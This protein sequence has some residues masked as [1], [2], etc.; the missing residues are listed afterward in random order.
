MSR[1]H[2]ISVDPAVVRRFVQGDRKAQEI[3]YRAY[4]SAVYTLA[5]R[6]LRDEALAEEATQDTF[7]DAIGSARKLARTQ[8]LAGWIRTIAVNHCLMRLR[9]PWYKRR[10]ALAEDDRATADGVAGDGADRA[11]VINQALGRLPGEARMVVWMHCVEGYTHD[12]IGRAFGHTASFSKSLLARAY[13]TLAAHRD[14]TADPVAPRLCPAK[15]HDTK[16]PG[17]APRARTSDERSTA[18]AVACTP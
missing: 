1:F 17:L 7:V 3:V 10:D 12:E 18:T 5:V 9:S 4:A 6:M 2:S 15:S 8:A 16:V 11:L 13:R 14:A